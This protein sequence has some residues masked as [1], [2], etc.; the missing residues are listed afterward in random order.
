MKFSKF[1]KKV[2]PSKL[3]HRRH[4][5]QISRS[6]GC[7]GATEK[8]RNELAFTQKRPKVA[9][10]ILRKFLI[11]SKHHIPHRTPD[12]FAQT[13]HVGKDGQGLVPCLRGI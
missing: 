2:Q 13:T 6:G 10:Q 12:R 9:L 5:D 11:Q 7:G 1:R 4:G 8:R 3:M